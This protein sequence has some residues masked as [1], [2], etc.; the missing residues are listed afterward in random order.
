MSLPVPNLDD[1]RFQDFVDDAKR[2]VQQRCPEWTDHN[3]S[4]PGVT[5]IEA[6]AAMADQIVFRLNRVPE[7]HYLKFLD[8]MGV[9]LFPATAARAPVTLWLSA[10]RSD[11]VRVPAG[12]EIATR[13]CPDVKPVTF[14]TTA[15]LAIVSTALAAVHTRAADGTTADH[16]DDLSAPGG[17]RCFSPVPAVDDE[18]LL[19]LSAAA[20][21]CV[22]ALRL[23]CQ[24]N[25]TGVDPDSPPLRWEAWTA[26]GWQGCEVERDGTRA[27]NAAG[28]VLLHLPA[29]HEESVVGGTRAGWLRARVVQPR[30]GSPWY[31]ASP[32][33]HGA[34]AFTVGGTVDAVHAELV[35]GEELGTTEGV[36]SQRFFVARTPVLPTD[37]PLRLEV[38]D[39]ADPTGRG[40]QQWHQVHDFAASGPDD[41]HF[42]LDAVEGT[43][44]LGPAVRQPD[45][46]VRHY[47][48]VPARGA[49]VRLPAY[50]TGGGARGNVSAMT[51]CVLRQSI[52]YVTAVCNRSA[53]RGGRDAEGVEDAKVRGPLE[54]QGTHRAVTA[55]DY[56]RVARTA[57]PELAR[58]R[59]LP[60][61]DGVVRVLLVPSGGDA[62]ARRP[63]ADLQPSPDSLR[64]V[65]DAIDERRVLGAR[66]VV[67]PPQYRGLTVVGQLRARAGHAA[68]DVE[69]AALAA[70]YRHH[71]PVQG[72]AEGTGWEFGRAVQYGDV[73]A[74]LQRVPGVD[75]VDDV[76]LY[77][78]DP[79]TGER[80]EACRTV[81]LAR[82][83]L[84]VGHDHRLRVVPCAG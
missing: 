38:T 31:S 1:R 55:D 70:L 58:A 42:V 67:E 64:R 26:R 16:G 78:V 13:R 74:V 47:G 40:W 14:S 20:P 44:E 32:R 29:G 25:G 80:G 8:L 43:V 10:P 51:L 30:P 49:V 27:L 65:A 52:P 77:P 84:V 39:P 72:G 46:T 57:A 68:A 56:E 82:G 48:R 24:V 12:T 15:D 69:A 34:Q 61:D 50:R 79:V 6:F 11:A 76:R 75:A 66:V 5:L 23:D 35:T 9:R 3:V 81:P 54:L 17:V 71:D 83:A 73:F 45:G 59:C 53:A 2:M 33:L 41:L 21:S 19:G 63:F 22:V 4:D 7:H 37:E 28:D 18:L 36:G 62:H 60:D